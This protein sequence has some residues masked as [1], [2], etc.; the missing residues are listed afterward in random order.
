MADKLDRYLAVFEDDCKEAKSFRKV[1]RTGLKKR[2]YPHLVDDAIRLIQNDISRGQDATPENLEIMLHN[3]GVLS[4][5]T[6]MLPDA[7]I[8]AV[9]ILREGKYRG[10]VEQMIH[11]GRYDELHDPHWTGD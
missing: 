7:V 6:V 10:M 8:D 11:E 5:G 1:L 4:G 3:I 2:S 9:K